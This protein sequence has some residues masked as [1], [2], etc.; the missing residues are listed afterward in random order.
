LPAPCTVKKTFEAARDSGAVF[1]GQVKGNQP[2]LLDAVRSLCQTAIPN[3]RIQS[4]DRHRGRRE[5]RTVEIFP[6]PEAAL[7]RPITLSP[8]LR[9]CSFR[10]SLL[11]T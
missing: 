10:E 2:G 8:F 11:T 3:E 7:A 4:K 6:L 9:L 5:I 1:I